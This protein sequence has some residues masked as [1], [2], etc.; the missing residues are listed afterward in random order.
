MGMF[1]GFQVLLVIGVCEL[2]LM[3]GFVM[4]SY[5][6]AFSVWVVACEE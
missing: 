5:A 1:R 3:C 4:S 2:Y 6:K